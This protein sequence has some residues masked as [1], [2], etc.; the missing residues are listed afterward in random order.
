MKLPF[1][2]LFVL[3]SGFQE[4]RAFEAGEGIRDAEVVATADEAKAIRISDIREYLKNTDVSKTCM[5]EM[6]RRRR[7]LILKLSL[8][9][10][11]APIEFAGSVFVLGKAGQAIGAA[12]HGEMADLAGAVTGMFLGGAGVIIYTG[13]DATVTAV[14]LHRQNLILK[15]LGEQYFGQPGVKTDELYAMY[16]KQA[17]AQAMTKDQVVASLI[18]LDREGALCDGRLKRKP[19]VRLGSKLKYQ[20]VNSKDFVKHLLKASE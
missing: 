16:L 17:P 11:L 8:K 5:D 10:V 15:A 3:I 9:P 14:Q 18:D 1:F 6:L 2:A 12:S 7:Q 13:I 20:V 4:A 19:L